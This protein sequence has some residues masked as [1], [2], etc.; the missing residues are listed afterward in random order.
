MKQYSVFRLTNKNIPNEY[1]LSSSTKGLSGCK[2]TL[3]QMFKMYYF[4]C[5]NKETAKYLDFYRI[6]NE[7][8]NFD[9]IEIKFE[10]EFATMEEVENYK[11]YWSQNKKPTIKEPVVEVPL[12]KSLKEETEE[13]LKLEIEKEKDFSNRIIEYR[14]RLA[15]VE[16]LQQDQE[17]KIKTIQKFLELIK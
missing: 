3:K 12:N 15:Q 10:K 9:D 14:I 13:L 16:L 1:V 11:S 4:Y 7:T 8:M 6:F 17:E 2:L 5:N